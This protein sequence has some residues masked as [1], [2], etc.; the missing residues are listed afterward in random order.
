LHPSD[1][2][3]TTRPCVRS[4]MASGVFSDDLLFIVSAICGM[5]RTVLCVWKIELPHSTDLHR[6][7][8]GP[9]RVNGLY[10]FRTLLDHGARLAPRFRLPGRGYESPLWFLRGRGKTDPERCF[11]QRAVWMVSYNLLY[12]KESSHANEPWYPQVS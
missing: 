6:P 11:S 7:P 10:A 2:K 3:C 5:L 12:R 1:R 4:L 9:E 8:Q